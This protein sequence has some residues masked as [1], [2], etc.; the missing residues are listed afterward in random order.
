MNG[1]ELW[2][3]MARVICGH[4]LA[5]R[6]RET[7]QMKGGQR[8]PRHGVFGTESVPPMICAGIDT[9]KGKL[10]VALDRRDERVV[11]ANDSAGHGRL[12]AWLHERGVRRTGIEASGGYEIDVV[13]ALRLDGFTVIV[14]QP[15]QVRAYAMFHRQLAKNDTLD[16]ALIAACTAATATLYAAPDP[17]LAPLAAKMT[18]I[19][20]VSA[21]IARPRTRLETC[22][23]ASGREFWEQEIARLAKI[24]KAELKALE[25]LI[26]QHCDR[27]SS[28]LIATFS[29]APD[30]FAISL[31]PLPR[32]D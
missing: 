12:L 31:Y 26:R 19:E 2:C 25:K 13:E 7:Y 24:E 20:Q 1:A 3:T 5:E 8:R 10:D 4:H 11:V 18:L 9:G 6:F 21:D 29:G 30:T 27:N 15:A 28:Y 17:R 14:F 16:A 32:D 23:G 22:R